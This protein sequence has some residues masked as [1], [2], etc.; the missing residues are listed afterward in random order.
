MRLHKNYLNQIK[1][2]SV[3]LF[4]LVVSQVKPTPVSE[5]IENRAVFFNGQQGPWSANFTYKLSDIITNGYNKVIIESLRTEYITQHNYFN[6]QWAKHAQLR[7][8]K[9]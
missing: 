7:H 1:H 6:A 4:S 2:Q 8:V 5:V 3:I 9:N